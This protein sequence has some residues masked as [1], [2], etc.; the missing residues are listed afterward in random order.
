MEN[1]P[2]S[3]V[4]DQKKGAIVSFVVMVLVFLVLRFTYYTMADPPAED[5][6]LVAETEITQIEL[7]EL[8]IE[9]GG[10]QGGAG[11]P[12]DDP[13][14]VKPKPQ[15]E[16]VITR[17]ESKTS[18]KTGQS[19]RTNGDNPDN[20]ATTL[21]HV[22]DPFGGGGNA[23]SGTRSGTFG[24]DEGV[25]QGGGNGTEGDDKGSGGKGRVR[26][27]NVNTDNVQSDQSCTVVLKLTVNA[28]GDVIRAEN[29]SGRTTTADQRIINR[30]AE[31][32]K[33]QIKYSKK[34]GSAMEKVSL[35]IHLKAT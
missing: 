28:E 1:R 8:V 4:A 21:R 26:L 20:T 30:V 13:V 29:I 18:V 14:D 34:P 15:T 16:K 10:S 25:Y 17:R 3:N 23:K 12:S 6:P 33:T 24:S 5:I 32:V 27:T 22:P 19:T 7:A 31:L 2:I 35:T 9:S 11:T